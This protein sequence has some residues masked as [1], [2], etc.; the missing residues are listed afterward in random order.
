MAIRGVFQKRNFVIGSQSY[1]FYV[2]EHFAQINININ[3]KAL[4]GIIVFYKLYKKNFLIYKTRVYY[5][6][7][8]NNKLL[9]Q[10]YNFVFKKFLL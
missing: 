10:Q 7:A 6:H 9:K 4:K 2:S 1:N 5:F 3:I 8:D